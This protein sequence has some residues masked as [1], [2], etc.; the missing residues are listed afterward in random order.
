[1]NGQRWASRGGLSG[2]FGLIGSWLLDEKLDHTVV[3]A[4]VENVARVHHA[5]PGGHTPVLVDTYLHGRSV[6]G[7]CQRPT[8]ASMSPEATELQ[9]VR[10]I[11]EL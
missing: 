4:L 9:V 10:G 2:F 8:I 3:V 6:T 11:C 1:M 7:A 5:H